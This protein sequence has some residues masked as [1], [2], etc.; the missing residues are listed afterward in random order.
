MNSNVCPLKN[1]NSHYLLLNTTIIPLCNSKISLI[2]LWGQE[3]VYTRLKVNSNQFGISIWDRVSLR[4]DL[5]ALSAFT[6]IQA[7]WN[8]RFTLSLGRAVQSA[9]STRCQY[10]CNLVTVKATS[11]KCE[12]LLKRKKVNLWCARWSIFTLKNRLK[13]NTEAVLELLHL[14]NILCRP[15]M[16][17]Y[18]FSN[19]I[20]CSVSWFLIEMTWTIC[21]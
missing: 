5:T 11:L 21:K 20:S 17:G 2:F 13:I 10:F 9:M 7:E 4:C 15:T 14:K 12:L 6:W 3:H 1:T 19:F 8:L 16:V 18:R